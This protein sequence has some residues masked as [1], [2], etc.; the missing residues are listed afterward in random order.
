MKKIILTAL[1]AVIAMVNVNAQESTFRLGGSVG[2]S[3]EIEEMGFGIDA[4]YSFNETWEVAADY[5]MISPDGGSVNDLDVNVH[6]MF[7]ES[8]YALA[9]VD[10]S[11]FKSDAFSADIFEEEINFPSLSISET[12]ANVGLGARF[13]LSDSLSLF[14]EAKYVTSYEGLFNIRAGILYSF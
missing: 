12:G 13:G 4:V 7:S 10:F 5:Y 14:T 3:S 11:T 8:F 2:Y 1:V 6:Y 9:G